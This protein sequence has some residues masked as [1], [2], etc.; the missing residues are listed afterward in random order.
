MTVH[1]YNNLLCT[2]IDTHTLHTRITS[3]TLCIS[4]IVDNFYER[5]NNVVVFYLRFKFL[6]RIILCTKKVSKTS[7]KN[8]K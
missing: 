1:H 7:F 2:H 5:I 4:D 6:V 3:H 8:V